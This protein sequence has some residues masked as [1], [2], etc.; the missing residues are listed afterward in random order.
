M[1]SLRTLATLVAP[2]GLLSTC[3]SASAD[4]LVATAIT[5]SSDAESAYAIVIPPVDSAVANDASDARVLVLVDTSASQAGQFR[6]GALDV[7]RS[8]VSSLG[9]DSKV[10]IAAVDVSYVILSNGYVA[11]ADTEEAFMQLEDRVPLGATNF[12]AAFDDV[13]SSFA[14]N[15]GAVVYIGDGMSASDLL[16]SEDL[17]SSVAQLSKAG[18]AWHSLAIGPK[19][20]SRLLGILSRHTGGT[21]RLATADSSPA[22]VGRELASVA[23]KSPVRVELSTSM[24]GSDLLSSPTSPALRTDRESVVFGSGA[25]PSEIEV[26]E[27]NGSSRTLKV[28]QS[29]K[30]H[31]YIDLL[32]QTAKKSGGLDVTITD[33]ESLLK[34]EAD[35]EDY[36][37]KLTEAGQQ[38]VKSRNEEQADQLIAE[39]D[40]IA[41]QRQDT[42][43]L[44]RLASQIFPADGAN[45]AADP[46]EDISDNFAARER[47]RQNIRGEQLSLEVSSGIEAARRIRTDDLAESLSILKRI[48]DIVDSVTD[49]PVDRQRQLLQ[50]IDR[51]LQETVNLRERNELRQI[52]LGDKLSAIESNRRLQER[53]AL[54]EERLEQ[55]I[56]RV[57]ALMAEGRTGDD[58]AFGAAEAV[59]I[60]AVNIRP[61]NGPATAARF[62]TEAANQ[63][64]RAFRLVELRR[65]RF[66]ETLYQ[67]ELSHVPF[68]DEPPIRY[69]APEVWKALTER[70]K[71]YDSVSVFIESPNEQRIRAALEEETRAQFPSTP[72]RDA[73]DFLS[74]YHDINILI[75]ERALLDDGIDS[76]QEIDLVLDGITLRSALKLM[77][78][79]LN[80]TYVIEDE[81]MKI[82]TQTVADDTLSTRVYPVGDLVIPIATPLGGGLGQG[83]G[84]VGGFQGQGGLGAG[85]QFGQ[86]GTGFG[87]FQGQGGG[88]GGAGFFSIPADEI[89]AV[90]F[91]VKKK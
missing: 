63:L 52:E 12:N 37:A 66:L 86:G 19:I 27:A 44:I 18:I 47:E 77:L 90:E 36:V 62:V 30:S 89:P 68:P 91:G 69:P 26:T 51:E 61:G 87:G 42:K 8:L 59:A 67:V 35:Y 25:I 4:D 54:E 11:P 34:Y 7:A 72:L 9:S 49:V 56:D 74:D 85:G 82:T 45:G 58:S 13:V 24:S 48:R 38:A 14:G 50:R 46:A 88:G 81:V 79:P 21:Y 29:E 16:T 33:R 31:D 5:G 20:D 23:I 17:R 3:L 40:R 64:N 78:K 80:L 6:T 76:D 1:L 57:R 83:L 2:L 41:P 70:R 84:G 39:V 71:K 15:G 53:F 10:A 73:I 55:L 65:D 75:D 28:R 32:V 43:S 22:L 60:E